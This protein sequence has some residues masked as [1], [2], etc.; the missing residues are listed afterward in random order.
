MKVLLSILFLLTVNLHAQSSEEILNPGYCSPMSKNPL[1]WEHPSNPRVP[2]KFCPSDETITTIAEVKETTDKSDKAK[3]T[4]T[5]INNQL[6]DCSEI[7]DHYG[8]DIIGSEVQVIT[9]Y[10]ALSHPGCHI[11][12]GCQKCVEGY[13][14]AVLK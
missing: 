2:P 13:S 8:Y 12:G 5:S 1:C 14:Y 9:K 6:F 3:F 10:F 4:C 11:I 7:V